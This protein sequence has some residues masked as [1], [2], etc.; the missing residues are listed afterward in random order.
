MLR[1][2]QKVF[3][4]P[5]LRQK[6]LF[7]I[8]MLAACRIGGS[9]LSPA[10]T[11]KSPSAFSGMHRRRPKPLPNGG[12][13]LGGAFSQ[14]TVIALGVVPYISASIIMQAAGRPVAFPPTGSPGNSEQG[15]RKINK[16]TRFLT[17][18]LSAFAVRPVCEVCRANEYMPGQVSSLATCSDIQIFGSPWLFYLIVIFTMT[19]GTV[20]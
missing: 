13:L 5:E 7:T 6:I 19:T 11:E 18:D 10:S 8:M 4:V 20:S 3:Q 9:S 15:K 12:Y 16:M 1:E 17:V 14:M 2:L